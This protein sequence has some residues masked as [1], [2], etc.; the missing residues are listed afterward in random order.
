MTSK[1]MHALVDDEGSRHVGIRDEEN[2]ELVIDVASNPIEN[3]G[4]LSEDG[5]GVGVGVP[6]GGG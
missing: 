3:V 5:G 6:E 1:K 4:A 2:G